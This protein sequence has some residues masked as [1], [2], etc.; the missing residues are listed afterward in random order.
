MARYDVDEVTGLAEVAF[1]V[2]DEWQGRGVGT[3]LFQPAARVRPSPRRARLHGGRARDQ[4]P[5]AS[6]FSSSGLAIKRQ[7]DAGVCHLEITFN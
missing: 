1:A 4:R 2:R 5:D 3:A 7:L 6:I